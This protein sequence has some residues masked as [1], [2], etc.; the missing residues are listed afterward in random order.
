M[1]SPL[2][3]V[4]ANLYM[5]SLEEAAI[6]SAELQPNLWVRYVDDTFVIWTHGQEE[7]HQFH[8]HLNN[9]HSN[10]QFTMEEESG[11]EL[12]FLDVLVTR[13]DERLLTSV[14]RKPTHTERYIPFNSHH[15]RKTI[16]GVLRSMR[17]RAH[18]ICDPSTKPQ[19]LHH[20]ENVFEA[21]GFPPNLVKKTLQVPP[22]SAPPPPTEDPQTEEPQKTLRTPYVRG[23]SEKLE[24]IC[25]SLGIRS[26]FTPART[27]KRTLM[28]VKSRLPDE[29][30][31]GVVYQIPCNN[32]DYVYTGESKRTLKVRMT[33]HKRAVKMSDPN[34]GIAVHVAKSQHSIDWPGAKVMRTVQGYWER[35]TMEAIEI[36]RSKRSMNLDKGL[37]LPSLWNPVLDQT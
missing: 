14:Y 34:N 25:A 33:E 3:P 24:R 26:V 22:K 29:K 4:I 23:L 15:H 16:T 20:L 6:S 31:K 7:L 37:L 1:G 21:N 11:C 35:R 27:L 12:A 28:K 32:C 36:R 13:K 30:K 17:D 9:Q 8:Q 2:L 10:I 19:E 18:R 5:E